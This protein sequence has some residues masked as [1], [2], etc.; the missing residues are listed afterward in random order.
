MNSWLANLPLSRKLLVAPA[1]VI[2]LFCICVLFI[3]QGL[4]KVR[5]AEEKYQ[6]EVVIHNELSE[7]NADAYKALA[8]ASGGF[9]APRI[10]SLF[11]NVL[12]VIDSNAAAL[13]RRSAGEFDTLEAHALDSLITSYRKVLVDLQDAA[14]GDIAFASMYLGSAQERFEALS[15]LIENRMKADQVE[16]ERLLT[17]TSRVS[18]MGLLGAALL[19]LFTALRM[20]RRIAKPIQDLGQVARQMAAGDLS[21]QI[22]VTGRDEV[23]ELSRSVSVL[24][25]SLRTMV[26]EL[27]D[28]IHEL[29]TSSVDLTDMADQLGAGSSD[30]AQRSG[31]VSTEATAMNS[32]MAGAQQAVEHTSR[33]MGS[34]AAAAEEMSAA[35]AE[36][37]RSA[38]HARAIASEASV[39]GRDVSS[40]IDALGQA[41]S[42][43]GQVTRLI[44]DVS[45]QTRLLALNATIEAARAGEAGRGFAVV[46]GEVKNL[47][48]Q[49]QGATEEIGM[50]INQIQLAVQATIDDMA[51]VSKVVGQIQ[52]VVDTI[53]ATVE[54]QSISTREIATRASEVSSEVKKVERSVEQGASAADRI[55][56]NVSGMDAVATGLQRSGGRLEETARAL[57]QL[58]VGL[59]QGISRFKR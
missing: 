16:S 47:A 54:E 40:R 51:A 50:K 46:A 9:P 41:A 32:T 13:R 42:E 23:G 7:A 14:T 38:E 3:I 24:A 26:R 36:V 17:L 25:E 6:E 2:F 11:K 44:Q 12:V 35:I 31:A 1:A 20:S 49:T 27:G 18:W 39:R 8:W 33:D 34:V 58:V 21:V 48:H 37:S 28:G 29:R 19:G 4:V 30:L 53:A 45:T 57:G 52:G 15:I 56:Q 59:E 43:I 55:T 22:D 5:D 10:D